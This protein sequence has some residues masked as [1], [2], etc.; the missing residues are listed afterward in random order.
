MHHLRAFVAVFAVAL[1][2]A[3][4]VASAHHGRPG[5]RG[6]H[7]TYPH[8]SHLCDRVAAGRV[9]SKL[10][11]DTAQITAAC[12]QL[13]TSFTNAQNAY[14]TAVAPLRQQALDA[15]TQLRQTCQLARQNHDR[16][17]C[18]QAR[19]QTLTTLQTLRAQVRTAAQ[20]YYTAVRAARQAFWT[21]IGSLRGGASVPEDSGS[22]AA[23]GSPIP[24]NS[25][26][27]HE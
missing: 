27:G 6:E 1:L 22:F 18:R 11:G 26:V 12:S 10:A 19:Q 4:A 20:A 5:Q 21:T 14:N 8:A 15:L 17:A 23:P 16:A 24:S 2:G 7:S 13:S 3:P 9:P 25:S